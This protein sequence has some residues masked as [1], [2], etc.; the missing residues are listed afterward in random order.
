WADWAT[1][2]V[3]WATDR[4]YGYLFIP[5]E[6]PIHICS[7]VMSAGYRTEAD[8]SSIRQMCGAVLRISVAQTP[9]YSDE[10]ATL[11]VELSGQTPTKAQ[12]LDCA[13]LYSVRQAP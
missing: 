10:H 6:W 1:F 11:H 12:Q 2:Y 9:I 5:S 13:S 8:S 3:R 4:L 7:W